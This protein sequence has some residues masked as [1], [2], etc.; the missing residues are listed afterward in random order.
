M[1]KLFAFLMLTGLLF[2]ISLD[3][4]AQDHTKIIGSW[5]FNAPDADQWYQTGTIV[6]TEDNSEIKGEVQFQDGYKVELS[7]IVFKDGE[8]NF[9]LYIDYER[10]NVSMILEKNKLSGTV[11]YSDGT[12]DISAEQE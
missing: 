10:I 6:F 1:K 7:D 12:L 9:G 11:D 5:S 4:S 8:L 2:S 3:I